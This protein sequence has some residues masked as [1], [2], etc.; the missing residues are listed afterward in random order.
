MARALYSGDGKVLGKL[1]PSQFSRFARALPEIR[2]QMKEFQEA[3]KTNA[4]KVKEIL[5]EG[6]AWAYVYEL[7]FIEQLAY[8]CVLL[9]MHNQLIEA[10]QDDD[11]QQ[12]VLDWMIDGSKLDRWYE[13]NLDKVNKQHLIWLV[14]TL[15]RNILSIMLYHQSMGALVAEVRQGNDEA[16]FKAVRVDRSVL[17]CPTFADRLAKAELINDK[18]FY[19]HLRSALKGPSKKHQEALYDLRYA[20]V[21]LRDMGFDKYT[22]AQI[23]ALFVGNGLYPKHPSAIKNIRKQIQ[24]SK[25][26][27]TI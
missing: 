12:A 6:C 10:S 25:K 26:F 7:G 9:G 27:S 11:P 23:E 4:D 8:L 1:T 17:A 24:D 18:Q 2:S 19:I 5:G 20:I 3:A 14:V 13:T 22:D 16:F 15:Q 21:L